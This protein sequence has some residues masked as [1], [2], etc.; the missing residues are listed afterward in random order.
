M[1]EHTSSKNDKEN[2]SGMAI[3]PTG[4]N[5][6]LAK[7]AFAALFTGLF[8]LH[9]FSAPGSPILLL[10]V[11]FVVTC[12]L[13]WFFDGLY[14][15]L[16]RPRQTTDGKPDPLN[17]ERKIVGYI[18]VAVLSILLLVIVVQTS[19]KPNLAYGVLQG[20][21]VGSWAREAWDEKRVL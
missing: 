2:A 12:V 6:W 4:K 18:I 13:A 15:R 17:R 8:I 7:V 1:E 19:S 20:L 9:L 3:L 16:M 5:G 21:L 14:K 11:E 10:V